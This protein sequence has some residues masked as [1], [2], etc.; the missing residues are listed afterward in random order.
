MGVLAASMTAAM[1]LSTS[2]QAQLPGDPQLGDFASSPYSG[3]TVNLGGT[4]GIHAFIFD[5]DGSQVVPPVPTPAT[6]SARVRL[7]EGQL[8]VTVDNA[9][10]DSLLG[11]PTGA[12]IRGP[13]PPGSNA[14]TIL[15]LL[16]G[17]GTS[18]TFWITDAPVTPAQ[19]QDM[20]GGL[21]YIEV[22]TDLY[23]AGEIRGQIGCG[24]SAQTT[25]VVRNGTGVNPISFVEVSPPHM[26]AFWETT[27]DIVTPGAIA[28]ALVL[29]EGGPITVPVSGTLHGELLI[30]P[31][32]MPVDIKFGSHSIEV[33]NACGLVGRT[34]WTQ[35][36]T[37]KAGDIQLTNAL[38]ITIGTY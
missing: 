19:A 23:P 9:S 24:I 14:P 32:F 18:G 4:S 3:G 38:D 35:A 31:P 16:V 36:V 15:P 29:A 34:F 30:L 1:L 33:P 17:G 20:I 22:E 2:A 5:L 13:A 26:A 25:T 27:V 10:F 28:S 6:G 12:Y 7:N 11:N 8:T 37:Y 21:T